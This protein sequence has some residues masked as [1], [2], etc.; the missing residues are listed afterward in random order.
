MGEPSSLAGRE[1]VMATE[2]GSSLQVSHF[3][4]DKRSL[5][6]APSQPIQSDVSDREKILSHPLVFKHRASLLHTA[7]NTTYSAAFTRCHG[8]PLTEREGR[9]IENNGT[10]CVHVFLMETRGKVLER[11][12]WTHLLLSEALT[13]YRGTLEIVSRLMDRWSGITSQTHLLPAV[14]LR[15]LQKDTKTQCV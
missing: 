2:A 3:L 4:L 7:L 6:H 9:P 15:L 11:G 5:A 1:T 13:F 12:W 8:P 10:W 14:W